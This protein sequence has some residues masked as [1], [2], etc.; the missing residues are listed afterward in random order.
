MVMGMVLVAVMNDDEA[1]DDDGD[2]GD[3]DDGPLGGVLESSW[4]GL[5]CLGASWGAPWGVSEAS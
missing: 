3:D 4:D 2:D 1:D 5:G